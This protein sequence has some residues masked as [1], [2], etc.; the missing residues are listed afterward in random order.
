M[1]RPPTLKK[2]Q[3]ETIEITSVESPKEIKKKL[4]VKIPKPWLSVRT[5]DSTEH[6]FGFEDG[7]DGAKEKHNMDFIA[8]ALTLR[9]FSSESIRAGKKK[10]KN[11][12]RFF[13]VNNI[14]S[15]FPPFSCC[16]SIPELITMITVFSALCFHCCS[17]WH[18]KSSE[19]LWEIFS[20]FSHDNDFLIIIALRSARSSHISTTIVSSRAQYLN[21]FSLII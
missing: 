13:Q 14:V 3:L 21:S 4:P 6:F 12:N 1:S 20:L 10:E 7:E 11:K 18:G 8:L 16:S 9:F 2:S 15:L 17:L 19:G 5:R